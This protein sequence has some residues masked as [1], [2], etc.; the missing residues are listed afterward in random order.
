MNLLE[1]VAKWYG[2][3]YGLQKCLENC[4]NYL[5]VDPRSESIKGSGPRTTGHRTLYSLFEDLN[6][7][8]KSKT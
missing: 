8:I 1:A 7:Q 5:L 4:D 2:C 6:E 3:P